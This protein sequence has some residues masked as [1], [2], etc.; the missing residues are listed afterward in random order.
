MKA[1]QSLVIIVICSFAMFSC[2]VN[3]ICTD[4]DL[5][6]PQTII[7]QHSDSSSITDQN[8]WEVYG[9]STLCELVGRALKNNKD[10][11]SAAKKVE[12]MQY[13]Y[14]IG[15]ANIAP[16]V[17][18]NFSDENE[19][20]KSNG[21]ATEREHTVNL[22]TTLSWEIDLYG[23][24]R[25]GK[26]QAKAE[27]L[28]SVEGQRAVQMALIADVASSY[29]KLI[30]YRK[31][32][33]I[34]ENTLSTRTFRLERAKLRYEAGLT[35]EMVY[36]QVQLEYTTAL[37]QI[38]GIKKKINIEENN[39]AFLIGEY[40]NTD[41]PTD[42]LGNDYGILEDIEVGIPSDLIKR[43]PDVRM[44]Y[45]Q[46]QAAKA[47]AGIAY[48]E[49][50]PSFVISL[51][52]GFEE[53]QFKNMFKSFYSN[54]IGEAVAP[55]VGFAKRQANYKAS[56]AAFE[57]SRIGY[58]KSVMNAFREVEDAVITYYECKNEILLK[59]QL[60]ATSAEYN[61][62]STIQYNAGSSEYIDVLDAMRQLLDARLKL[63]EAI[64]NERL[65][66]IQL[67]KSLGGGWQSTVEIEL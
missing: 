47:G 22:N 52:A 13:K 35:S 3:K 5:K 41:I 1:L 4:P 15:K 24:L 29:Y 21:S 16:D 25:W 18:L 23:K 7:A 27:Y 50:F 44:A 30:G 39:L 34:L 9:D 17:N 51:T 48:A 26:N 64:I 38:P 45:Q 11:L 37:S 2:T 63:N 6:L 32:L 46:M 19:W 65:A 55:I 43:R 8:W 31:E 54:L 66:I 40:S 49:R 67:Y 20:S 58:E 12:Q 33:T 10:I 36:K 60:V 59:E 57:N 28:T 53:N 14:R 56:L 42:T 61:T 62:L